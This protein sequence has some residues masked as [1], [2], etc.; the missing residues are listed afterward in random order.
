MDKRRRNGEN[1]DIGESRDVRDCRDPRASEIR[2]P[3]RSWDHLDNYHKWRTTD[4]VRVL[5]AGRSVVPRGNRTLNRMV[6]IE[7]INKCDPIL[8]TFLPFIH[9]RGTDRFP[10]FSFD[11]ISRF[12]YCK[13][14]VNFPT[15]LNRV[16]SILLI[17][18]SRFSTR[19][20]KLIRKIS[21]LIIEDRRIFVSFS[22][23]W[24]VVAVKDTRN[25]ERTRTI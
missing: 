19:N 22:R 16:R 5:R 7:R 9:S 23:N 17:F 11:R 10:I 8:P 14:R 6:V 24:I 18:C 4:Y 13:R 21:I 20:T 3:L 12:R 15:N 1:G 2:V 25:T